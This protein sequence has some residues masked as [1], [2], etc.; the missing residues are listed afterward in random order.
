MRVVKR[1]DAASLRTHVQTYTRADAE[2]NTD[3]WVGYT[4]PNRKHVKVSRGLKEWA[5]DD[6]GEGVCEAH[7]NTIEGTWTS[8]RNFL[9]PFR[10]V[11][12]QNLGQYVAICEFSPNV[13]NVTP[14]FIAAPVKLH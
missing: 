9:R 8:V 3:E 14:K 11:H 12:K 1:T 6:D 10:G 13:R 2:V 5:R 4:E 7:V